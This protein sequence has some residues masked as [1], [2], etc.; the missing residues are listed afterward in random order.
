LQEIREAIETIDPGLLLYSK[1]PHRDD[2]DPPCS[3]QNPL[4]CVIALGLP[5]KSYVPDYFPIVIS[6]LLVNQSNHKS[7]VEMYVDAIE[8]AVTYYH[9]ITLIFDT[10]QSR[11]KVSEALIQRQQQNGSLALK[12]IQFVFNHIF[13]PQFDLRMVDYVMD[14]SPKYNIQ[15]GLIPNTAEVAQKLIWRPYA[16]MRYEVFLN[17]TSSTEYTTNSE[18]VASILANKPFVLA[19]GSNRRDYTG[20]VLAANI[21]GIN[22]IIADDH[23]SYQDLNLQETPHLKVVQVSHAEFNVLLTHAD[24]VII[25]SQLP[26]TTPVGIGTIARVKMANKIPIAV[27]NTGADTMI[28]HGVDGF[29]VPDPSAEHEAIH[30]SY[31]KLFEELRDE[32]RR[33]EVE[34]HIETMAHS[35]EVAGVQMVRIA[36]CLGAYSMLNGGSIM[37]ELHHINDCQACGRKD[38]CDFWLFSDPLVGVEGNYGNVGPK[39]ED[40]CDKVK[41]AAIVQVV[42]NSISGKMYVAAACP[43]IL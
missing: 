31:Q 2:V 19:C 23:K 5:R 14:Y 38:W 4:S 30:G 15:S 26:Q 39:L 18:L 29:F 33:R 17:E 35:E 8:K 42:R 34:T 6:R 12:N 3:S 9:G 36:S 10:D 43:P 24:F 28:T 20:A 16:N 22:L 21:T 41:S 27:N 32:N 1:L 13:E 11:F 40:S 25:P 37:F 7:T